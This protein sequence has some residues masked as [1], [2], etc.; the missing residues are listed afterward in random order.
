MLKDFGLDLKKLR[1]IKGISIAEIS[2]ESRINIKFLQNIENGIFDFQPETYI[3]SF[4]KAY[5]RA[6]NENENQILNEYDKAKAGFYAR[7][8]FAPEDTKDIEPDAKLRI[9]VLDPPPQKVESEQPVYS[10]SIEEN[11][12]DYMKHRKDTDDSD[13]EYSNRSVTQKVLLVILILV[14]AAGIYFLVD[15]LN[16]SKEK[17]SDVKP[18]TFN[19]MSSEYE[20]KITNKIDSTRIKDS[21]KTLV[22][23]SLR[24]TVKAVKDIK[25][26]VYIDDKPEPIDEQIAAKDSIVVSALEKFRFSA[27]TSQN[28]DIFLN[29][30]YLKKTNMSSGATSIKNLII[31]KDGI[32]P[33]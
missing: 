17:K 13:R 20:N 22:T 8:K 24:L 32:A 16:N 23:D 11:K 2:A 12:P 27:N 31:T 4:I 25:I 9:S 26:K 1:E 7:R 21:L 29:G 33:Q 14:V 18:K 28:V 15:Y 30:R 3:R 10:K 19:E 6:L 5:A